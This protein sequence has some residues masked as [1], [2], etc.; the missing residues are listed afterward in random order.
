MCFGGILK[1]LQQLKKPPRLVLL[2]EWGQEFCEPGLRKRFT[3]LVRKYA[4]SG[5]PILP[6]DL[7]MRVSIPECKVRCK[8][9]TL[10]P[11]N[12]IGVQDNGSWLGYLG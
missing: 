6:A 4:P 7:G 9:G 3:E 8:A 11:P 12:E 5:I 10:L 1:T 2:S